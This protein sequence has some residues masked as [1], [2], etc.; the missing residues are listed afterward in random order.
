MKHVFFTLLTFHFSLFTCLFAS[1]FA[2]HHAMEIVV[3]SEPSTK[4]LHVETVVS[5]SYDKAKKWTFP[6]SY[7]GHRAVCSLPGAGTNDSFIARF[8]DDMF[9]PGDCMGVST[10]MDY[11]V[12]R[13]T[14]TSAITPRIGIWSGASDRDD[15]WNQ[16]LIDKALTLPD[17]VSWIGGDEAKRTWYSNFLSN[18]VALAKPPVI[19]R[20]TRVRVVRYAVDDRYCYSVG[21]QQR[22]VLDRTFDPDGRD[23]LCEADLLGDGQFDIDWDYLQNEVVNAS[24]VAQAGLAVSNMTY[25]VVIGD[26]PTSFSGTLG[27]NT[28]VNAMS[29]MITRRFEVTRHYPVAE[30]VAIGEGARPALKWSIPDEEPWA[31]EYGTSY[32]AFRFQVLED[33]GITVVTTS[34]VHRLPPQDANGFFTWIPTDDIGATVGRKWRVAMYNANFKPSTGRNEA[35]SNLAEFTE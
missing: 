13:L 14:R 22:A 18:R 6:S 16:V 29:T 2:P 1:P 25:L 11:P 30:N 19:D 26:G 33:A 7:S 20:Q 23:Y 15:D 34:T 10:A 3:Y 5:N 27:T 32:T 8:G 4:P 24:G 21:V 17:V 9:A 12:I 28:T 35:W 31:K